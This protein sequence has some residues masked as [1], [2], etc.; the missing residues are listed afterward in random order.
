VR[1]TTDSIIENP[2][3]LKFVE[4][5]GPQ[6]VRALD[7]VDLAQGYPAHYVSAGNAELAGKALIY[8]G[9]DDVYYAIRF[10]A[11]EDKAN[12]PRIARFIDIYQKSPAVRE[13]IR[14]SY[15]GDERLY[16]LPWLAKAEE[17]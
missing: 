14:K 1:G 16:S 9:I 15:A 2:K 10:V 7:D 12:D 17:K 3:H 5:E 6:L 8:S 13:Q 11:R 4:I